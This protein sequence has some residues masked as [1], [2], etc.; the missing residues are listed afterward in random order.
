MFKLQ[1]LEITG[2]KSF[3]D[4]TEIV[5][6]G[7][8]I[9]A[10][11]G[12]NGCG[13]CVHGDT[14]ITL[15]DGKEIQVRELVENALQNCFLT[16]QFDDGFLTRENPQNVEILSLNPQT[17][18]LEPRKVSA[19]IKRE[20]TAKLLRIRTLSGREIEATPYHPLF[21]LA[22]GKLRT[23]RAD[24]VKKG[25]RIAVPRMLKTADKKINFSLNNC[26]DNF[27]REDNVFLPFS[28]N[29]KNWTE[30]GKDYFGTI[31]DW[32]EKAQVSR[33]VVGGLRNKQSVNVAE[34]QKLSQ[35]FEN[36]FFE[37]QIKSKGTG[38]LKIP[39]DFSPDLARFLGLLIAEGR[40]TSSN[41]VWFVNSDQAINREFE[42][43]AN[44]IFDVRVIQKQ[45]K[46]GATDN[47]IFSKSLCRVL[48]RFFNFSIN[49][50]S[51]EKEV[52]PQ[53]FESDS[54]T[55]WA[56]LSGL[57][58]GDAYLC[59][60]P[61]KSNG[62]LLNYIEY[63]T[64]SEKLAKQIVSLLLQLGV[65]AYLRPKQKY[66]ANT[67]EKTVR[68]YYSVLIYGSKQ[69]V[70]TAG[71]LSFVGEKQKALEK[72]RK[73]EIAD[74]PNR[75]LVPGS[76]ELV[77]EAVKLA[78]IKVKPNR[79]N[80]PKIAA[81]TGKICEASRSGLNEVIEQI[82]QLSSNTQPA[83]NTLKELS[84]LADSDVFWDEIVSVEEIEPTENWV[85]DLSIDETHNFVAGNI[86]VHN[87]NVSES[88]AWVLGEQRVKQLRGAE[89]KDVVFQGTSKRKPSGM[90][91][92]VLHLVRD[93]ES[94]YAADEEDLSDIDE[95]LSDLD[96]NAVQVEDFEV[97]SNEFST[98]HSPLST[99]EN[100][101]H[102]EEIEVEKAQ[103]AQ[104]GSVQIV[105]KKAKS[106]RHWRPRSV[107][108]D[109]APGEAISVTR[110]LYLSGESEYQLNGK[111]CRLRD[112]QDL[113]A[114]TGLSGAHY[115]IIEQ[116]RIGQILSAK[117][118][119]R[120]GL[121]EEAAGISKFRTRQ[122]AA[123]ARLE[124]AKS[125]L[126]RISD[127]VSEIDKQANA[128]RRQAAKTR[129]YKLLR[130]EF[131]VLLKNLF[132]AE[133][134]FL[135]AF[136]NELEE[137]LTEAVK[138][139]R[140]IF[141]RVA[142]K[143]EAFREA[144]QKAREAEE[145]LSE[146][147][148]RHAENVL[149]RDRNA[150]EKTY[151]QEQIET[152]KIRF[153]VLK[154]E[155]EAT[156]QRLELFKAEIE[157]L[158]KDERK[159]L[160][161]AEKNVL[162]FQSAEKK[163][164]SK[165]QELRQIE[166]ELE[167]VRGEVLQHT[168][169]VERFAEIERQLENNLERL[170][171]RAEGL[172][173]EKIRAEE[174][175]AEHAEEAVKLEKDLGEK[176]EK[177]KAL[178]D[179]KQ[180]LLVES[181]AARNVLQSAEKSLRELQ[182]EFSRKKNRLETLQEL[183]EKRAV[184]APSVQKLFAEQAKIGVKFSGTLADKFNV[185]EKA[186]KAVENLFGAFL[187]TVLVET[188]ADAN[189][190][191]E[192]LKKSNLG[193]IAVL[194]FN[195]KAQKSK[196]K[197]ELSA[198]AGGSNTAKFQISNF[199]S[200]IANLIGVS[201]DFAEILAE[202]F[203]RE[204]TAQL[205]ENLGDAKTDVE[206][207]F[208]D[209]EGDFVLSGKLFVSG[210]ANANEKNSSL[211]AFKRELRELEMAIK[212]LTKYAEKSEKETE[213][214]RKVL[215]G[216]EEEIVDLQ[217]LI[218]QVER[219]LLSLE[220]QEKSARA[221]TERAERH[222]K[223][224]GEEI[225]QIEKE[226]GEI[227]A[228]QKEA[229][230]NAEKAE[231]ARVSASEKLTKISQALSEA[232]TRTE[233][234]NA[235]LNEKRTLAATSEERR[236]SAQNALRRV[237]NEYKEHD[238]RIARQNLEILETEA[239]Q[240]TLAASIAEIEAKI[241]SAEIEQ[242]AEQNEL[243]GATAHLK[244]AR[245]TADAMS[246]ELAELNKNSAEARNERA[247]LEIRQAEAM[248]KLRSVNE[249]CSHELN[250]S[251]VEL[252]ETEEILEDFDLETARTSADDLREKL[253]NFGAINMLALEELAEADERLLFLTS[254]RQDIIDS[255]AAAEEA[256]REIKERSRERFKEAFEAINANFIEFFQELFGGGRGEMTLLEAEDIL[257][258]GIEVVAQPPGKRL[259]NILLLSG[260]EKAMAAIALVM[261][262]FRYRPSPFC[263]LDEVDAPLD[264]ANVGRFV[265]KIAQMAEKTQFIVI[266]HNKRTME[267]ARALYGVT[268]QEAGI[269]KVVSVRFE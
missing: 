55:K 229:R 97:E 83:E 72:L 9:T 120:R 52:P 218:V 230:T 145:N 174:N 138:T 158:K 251:L 11:V 161:E 76:T 42:K 136:V 111:T 204:M 179:E 202:V 82:R 252:V 169:A 150:R 128:L 36:P 156:E 166:T 95:A 170:K 245:E 31:E 7:N 260:G 40:N 242:E 180:K 100:G 269:S 1:R 4:Y 152:L 151:R 215:A 253:E 249:N 63:A 121:I 108:L 217:S 182:N 33:S 235:V 44:E 129:R 178:H 107:A 38:F 48:E 106:K 70:E 175:H 79:Q 118:S 250:L 34:L 117:P 172:R 50:N 211:L 196:D 261:A 125:N 263:L 64:A 141:A 28:D 14:L 194:V 122:R 13:K 84:I 243:S 164:Q 6:T 206:K 8:G 227:G 32:T 200:Q 163:Y 220:I 198:V 22:N 80:F 116:G 68:T 46:K 101:F 75:D 69:L 27:K 29:L 134:R 176:R 39:Q 61:Q 113:F 16:E 258:A 102:S 223:V 144:T 165:L 265:D 123:E 153:G 60:R 146:I 238:S 86:I 219:D 85:Y 67:A 193:R 213:K 35:V 25:V 209:A 112:I 90:A 56:F 19:F 71:N 168:T 94:M 119:D 110:R 246:S 234:E 197:S 99:Q 207:S 57:F 233:A 115:A 93:E 203:P 232:R 142:E 49:S 185:E 248:T 247:A 89:M 5:F 201:D 212:D 73:I 226:L 160:A 74:N 199:K 231:K 167:T 190:T 210:K 77:R 139:E 140:A 131:R 21:T 37:N 177:I 187:Q 91:E 24:E 126:S 214:A 259:Q 17:L 2:F 96:E 244:N 15:S 62:K 66:A 188:D 98:L 216:K 225:A 236:R 137:K 132:T 154:G 58:E 208:V 104:V 241:S 224:V 65:F 149:E 195:A 228:K 12:P 254:Q 20:T 92:V 43:L 103:A 264:D 30:K 205:V 148:A 81:Y 87:S 18:K 45:Y 130:E 171:E 124:S 240:K 221:E 10:V 53:I 59:S 181:G 183:D 159:E 239:K 133:G 47:L 155:I 192:Y 109:F 222:K 41:Q 162:E 237:E 23:L 255:I 3:A 268:M 256:L 26:F 127:I 78:G 186:E 135:N 51:F 189:K 191:V 114:G 173:R 105:E 257:E 88:I 147:R 157:R 143:D 266:T 54:E 184:Y 262:I 267:A